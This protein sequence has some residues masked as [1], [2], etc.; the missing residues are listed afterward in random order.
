MSSRTISRVF[1]ILCV[2]LA[3]TTALFGYLYLNANNS[4]ETNTFVPPYIGGLSSTNFSI[5]LNAFSDALT[6]QDTQNIEQNTDI[7]KFVL[8]CSP[9]STYPNPGESCMSNW[10]ETYVQLAADKL[11]FSIPQDATLYLTPTPPTCSDDPY[12]SGGPFIV[13][14]FDNKGSGLPTSHIGNAIFTFNCVTCGSET[15]WAWSSVYL[16]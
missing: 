2:I 4:T 14:N 3:I 8:D 15:T 9:D 11:E 5:F 13:G 6:V 7:Q 16:C 10:K 1:P 12:H